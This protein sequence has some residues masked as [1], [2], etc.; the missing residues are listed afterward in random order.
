MD[1]WRRSPWTPDV[2]GQVSDGLVEWFS[3]LID[4]AAARRPERANIEIVG[5]SMSGY[6][7]RSGEIHSALVEARDRTIGR[8]AHVVTMPDYVAAWMSATR[9]EPGVVIL[10]GGG[11]F[12]FGAD[13]NLS[14]FAGGFGHRLGDEGSAY[15]IGLRALQATARTFDGRGPATELTQAI[16]GKLGDAESRDSF[17]RRVVS[18]PEHHI[19]ELAEIVFSSPDPKVAGQIIRDAAEEL[20]ALAATI[21]DA[22]DDPAV[23]LAGGALKE[24]TLQDSVT[25]LIEERGFKVAGGAGDPI[26]GC[27]LLAKVAAASGRI[28]SSLSNEGILHTSAV[29]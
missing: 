15:W 6:S 24:G 20:A 8:S 17:V 12:A 3:D 2:G 25:Q 22:F 29:C 16:K 14:S 19:A 10:S 7:A 9:G 13:E 18:L 23:Y 11:S 21:A 4:E 28:P 26:D 5:L 1:F 27:Y